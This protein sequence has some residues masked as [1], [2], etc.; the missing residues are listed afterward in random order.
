MSGRAQV[1]LGGV[2]VVALLAGA[3]SDSGSGGATSS[4]DSAAASSGSGGALEVGA[5]P[6]PEFASDRSSL[7]LGVGYAPVPYMASDG[8]VHLDYELYVTNR[9]PDPTT[10]IEVSV[11][12]GADPTNVLLSLTGSDLG[13]F[14]TSDLSRNEPGTDMGP[15]ASSI[16]Y[17]DLSVD[18]FDDVPET[19]MH[20]VES[21]NSEDGEP[22]PTIEGAFTAPQDIEVPVLA[23][24][25]SDGVWIAAEAC[26]FM[27]HHRRPPLTL[28]GQDFLAQRYAVDF[29]EIIDGELWEGD[30]PKDVD[31]WYTYGQDA[32]AVVDGT[33]SSV[34]DGDA[35]IT[36]F[37]PNPVPRTVDNITG[38]HVIIDMGNGYFVVYAHLQPGSLEVEVGDEVKVGDKLALVG[39]SG[40]TD[41]PHLH[42]H[43]MDANHVVQSHA[44]PFTFASY[45]LLGS[46]ESID[47]LLP[48]PFGEVGP[49]PAD[50]LSS[51][52]PITDAYPL[53]LD[54][55]EW[56]TG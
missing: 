27:S 53:E 38:N 4:S 32:L 51:P 7:R 41:A 34:L 18:G 30:D 11:V 52:E 9:R 43:V 49:E 17:I 13:E 20:V 29:I 39:N 2:A 14:M 5:E 25:V 44:I 55:I 45:D 28:N 50:L 10:V 19:L 33:V 31:A 54:I 36:P 8:R 24:P 1:L 35:D 6:V 12:D 40:N 21:E 42:I 23:Q 26:C 16:V 48:E 47:A 37:E 15:G 22:Y 46:F 3:C 56:T